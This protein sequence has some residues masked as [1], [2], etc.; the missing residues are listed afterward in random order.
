MSLTNY[1]FSVTFS[2]PSLL[3]LAFTTFGLVCQFSLNAPFPPFICLLTEAKIYLLWWKSRHVQLGQAK[4][5]GTFK[6]GQVTQQVWWKMHELTLPSH[7][8]LSTPLILDC[9]GVYWNKIEEWKNEK[10]EENEGEEKKKGA[11]PITLF[12]VVDLYWVE[13]N[14]GNPLEQKVLHWNAEK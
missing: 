10:K 7:T 9:P 4:H 12:C 8:Q 6:D 3:I 2:L 13:V 14:I 5:H 1:L 11:M